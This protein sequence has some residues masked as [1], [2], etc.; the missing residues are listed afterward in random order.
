MFMSTAEWTIAFALPNLTLK[1]SLDEDCV[2]IAP[3]SDSRV[4]ECMERN[5]AARHLLDGFTDQFGTKRSVSAMMYRRGV[6][7]Q[8]KLLPAL[9]SFRNLFALSCIINGWQCFIG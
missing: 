6:I 2:S 1:K 3:P 7:P 9:I 5:A 4:Q 8:A